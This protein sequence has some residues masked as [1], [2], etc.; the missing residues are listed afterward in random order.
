MFRPL[1]RIKKL[2]SDEDVKNLLKTERRGVF[3]CNGDDG[4]PYCVPVNYFYDEEKNKIFFHGAKNGHKFDS[5]KK[6]DKVCFTVYGNETIDP[7]EA[8]APYLQSVVVFGRC[9]LVDDIEYTKKHLKEFA[10]KYYPSEELVDEEV[11]SLFKAT[12]LYEIDIEHMCGKKI[13]EK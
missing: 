3:A 5:V 12:Q 2:I 8:W 4:Y 13:Q 11:N 9:K 1:R 7:N 10:M 6:D